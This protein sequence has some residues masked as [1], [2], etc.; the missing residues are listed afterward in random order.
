MPAPSQTS[1]PQPKPE[2]RLLGGRYLLEER[3]GEGGL[4]VVWRTRHLGL[5]R[6]VA[7]KL[8]HAAPHDPEALAR[9]QR[10]AEALGRLRHP[11]V[12]EVTDFGVDAETGVPYLVMELL[13]GQTLADLLREEGALPAARALPLLEALADAVDA[14]HAQGI[15]HRD[16]KPGNVSMTGVVKILDFGLAEI[17]ASA[18]EAAQGMLAGTQA[19]GDA[20]LTSTG[21]LLGTPLYAAPEV[22]RNGAACRASDIY[23]L[24][25]IAYEML[26]GRPPFTGSTAEVLAGHLHCEP[27]APGLAAPVWE[28]LREALDKEPARRPATAAVFVGRLRRAIEQSEAAARRQAELPRRL[29]LAAAVS[30]GA[31]AAGLFLP[32]AGIPAIERRLD[33]LRLEMAPRDPDP[34]ILLLTLDEASQRDSAVPLA[35]RAEEIGAALSEVLGAGARGVAVDLVLPLQWRQSPAFA[36]L[37]LRHPEKL[38]LAALSSDG[39]VG[40]TECISG[41]TT[42]A[43][44]AQQAAE[45]FGFVNIDEDPDHITR[46]GRLSFR[47]EPQGVTPSWAA[48]AAADLGTAPRL[49][50][51]TAFRI[52]HRIDSDRYHRLP[53][54]DLPAALVEQPQLFRDRLVLVGIDLPDAVDDRYDIPL[55]LGRTGAVSG[56][57]LQALQIDTILAGLPIRAAPRLPVLLLA[58]LLAGGAALMILHN[59]HARRAALCLA[60][61]AALYVA[62]S[63][64][65][66]ERTSSLLPVTAPCL[67]A[68]LG[69]AA[70]LTL[71]RFL[72]NQGISIS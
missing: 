34:R 36:D 7:L 45:L 59:G 62:T 72:P 51:G 26:T 32:P 8:L 53:W 17:A 47:N 48:H 43:L 3:L 67:V 66:F 40:G 37:V 23:S 50:A 9:F 27:P 52:D 20:R 44:G 61:L 46:T 31:L 70:G 57:A 6:G 11:H 33:D 18:Q 58:A 28:S 68:A 22:I 24:G 10:E 12:V 54:R 69:F 21:A 25:V 71:R 16:L 49:P 30:A 39:K 41:L 35:G 1:A 60:A 5:Q 2:P 56:L 38:T 42:A 55:P 15:L 13:A 4:G 19:D 14:A 63:F 64:F 65:V 29:L